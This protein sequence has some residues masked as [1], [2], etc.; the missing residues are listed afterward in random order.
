LGDGLIIKDL[1]AILPRSEF[2]GG[3]E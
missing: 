3:L 1:G 2:A